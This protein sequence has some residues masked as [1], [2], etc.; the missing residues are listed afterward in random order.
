MKPLSQYIVAA[1]PNTRLTAPL[2][3]VLYPKGT[4]IPKSRDEAYIAPSNLIFFYDA[5]FA[6]D[7]F[8]QIIS[9][10]YADTIMSSLARGDGIDLDGG[11]DA[12]T[13]LPQFS[14]ALAALLTEQTP[15]T[16]YQ[17]PDRTLNSMQIHQAAPKAEASDTS[18]LA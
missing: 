11:T 5:R 10:Y 9:Q 3:V 4:P 6:H 1:V 18:T 12:W 15:P 17:L 14:R 8:G 13:L 16:Q 7:I 2:N